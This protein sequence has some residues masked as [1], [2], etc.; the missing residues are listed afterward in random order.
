MKKISFLF[1]ILAELI[2][3]NYIK[4]NIIS[5]FNEKKEF[6]KSYINDKYLQDALKYIRNDNLYIKKTVKNQSPE[7]HNNGIYYVPNFKKILSDLKKSI[8][9]NNNVLSAYLFTKITDIYYTDI[10]HDMYIVKRKALEILCNHNDCDKCLMYS[11]YLEEGIGGIQSK[12][13]ALIVL[14]KHYEKCKN[15]KKFQ[16]Y[17]TIK[18]K[19]K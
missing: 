17:Y 10:T 15:D 19:T 12:I 1:F 5:F 2:F 3:A 8:L 13:G 18:E 7:L 6:Y 4:D 11:K 16:L 14:K 9:Q